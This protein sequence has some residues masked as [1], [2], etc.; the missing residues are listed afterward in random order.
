M[1]SKYLVVT[2]VL[3]AVVLAGLTH[4]NNAIAGDTDYSMFYK[5]NPSQKA[6]GINRTLGA[7]EHED[8]HFKKGDVF[9]LKDS[10]DGVLFIPG[11]N[12]KARGW[13]PRA[14]RL[15]KFGTEAVP[16][17]CLENM[18]L[19]H[20]TEGANESH[21]FVI[22][23]ADDESNGIII[24]Y[25]GPELGDSCEELVIHGGWAHGESN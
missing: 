13:N 2:A 3:C 9:V 15:K 25:G 12:M 16:I 18:M 7:R 21:L 6:W 4:I 10:G 17:L 24:Q 14:I 11:K 19:R 5:G 8:D 22:G 20:G 23:P 1:T